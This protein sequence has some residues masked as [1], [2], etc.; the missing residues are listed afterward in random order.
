MKIY[1]AKSNAANF[2]VYSL[3]KQKLISLGHEIIEFNGGVYT[4]ETLKEAD[5]LFIVPPSN[6]IGEPFRNRGSG[7]AQSFNFMQDS[8][9]SCYNIGRG[10]TDQILYFINNKGVK[11]TPDKYGGH[12]DFPDCSNVL[13]LKE[14]SVSHEGQTYIYVDY[15]NEL[16]VNKQDWK[17]EWA[18][19]GFDDLDM[20]VE[21]ILMDQ[22]VI[23]GIEM[24]FVDET[25][26]IPHLACRKL[27]K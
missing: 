11:V 4:P 5:F 9:K 21:S 27:F 22:P 8:S 20:N 13:I 23:V 17:T 15:P 26:V 24:P 19:I 14:I 10:Q 7:K 18:D 1:L 2:A 16:T 6:I 3:V 25:L 12:F